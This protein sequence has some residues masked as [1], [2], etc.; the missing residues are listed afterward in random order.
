MNK[1]LSSRQS[2]ILRTATFFL[3]A[4]LALAGY[5]Y[6]ERRP[7]VNDAT[8]TATEPVAIRGTVYH[9]NGSPA[10]GTIVEA[11][12]VSYETTPDDFYQRTTTSLDGEYEL[13]VLPNHFYLVVAR[14]EKLAA[15]PRTGFT[16]LPEQ[17]IDG[18]DFRL[19]PA[20]RLYGRV[21]A[22]D[23]RTA[24]P[25]RKILVEQ[26]G[27][28]PS[29]ATG[30]PLANSKGSTVHVVPSLEQQV[31]SNKQGDYEIFL[32]PGSY[33]IRIHDER[34]FLG[35]VLSG[36]AEKELNLRVGSHQ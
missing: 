6:F 27:Q 4:L 5:H 9:A 32:G 17:P 8:Q 26:I 13:K 2:K 33:M 7:V 24:E 30:R 15:R 36:E 11:S 3:I 31:R 16:L 19:K 20:T 1:N 21:S 29:P 25:N 22:H 28:E 34:D 14:G 10:V 12:G 35:I 23:G 18:L